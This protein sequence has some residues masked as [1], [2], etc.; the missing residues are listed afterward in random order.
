MDSNYFF[1][2]ENELIHRINEIAESKGLFDEAHELIMKALTNPKNDNSLDLYTICKIEVLLGEQII[3]IPT[4]QQWRKIKLEKL[5]DI[6][7]EE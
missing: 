2:R 1:K 4:K 7:N 6:N 3:T 5:N